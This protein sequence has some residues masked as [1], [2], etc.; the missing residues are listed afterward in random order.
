MMGIRGQKP[1]PSHLRVLDGTAKDIPADEPQPTGDLY[2]PPEWMSDTQAEGWR[3]AIANA[4]PGLL[5]MCDKSV[6]AIWVC[7][8]DVHALAAQVVAEKGSIVRAK[9]GTPMQNPYL[10]V[11]NKQALI[12][13]KASSE[14]GFSPT[15]R[16]RVKVDPNANRRNAFDDLRSLDDE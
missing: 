11:M 8:E 15:S 1:R 16:S 5:K 6:L 13:L 10:S 9:N 7:A 3:Y 12:M 14:M 4:P 2:E